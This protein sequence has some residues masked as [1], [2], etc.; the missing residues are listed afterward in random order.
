M[1]VQLGR[2]AE[3]LDQRDGAALTFVCLE[4]G[5]GQ[6]VTRDHALRCP[7]LAQSISQSTS[8]RS[9]SMRSTSSIVRY[10]PWVYSVLGGCRSSAACRTFRHMDIQVQKHSG[11]LHQL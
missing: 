2:R 8:K 1:N 10:L 4:P 11:T 5:A 3:A 9:P 6:Q 7:V